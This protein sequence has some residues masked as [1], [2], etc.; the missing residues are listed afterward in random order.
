[1]WLNSKKRWTNGL[2]ALRCFPSYWVFFE[3]IILRFFGTSPFPFLRHS[4]RGFIKAA[5]AI[6]YEK[7][8]YLFNKSFFP[9]LWTTRNARHR[10]LGPSFR[11]NNW[12]AIWKFVII[13]IEIFII[14]RNKFHE[15]TYFYLSKTK[16]FDVSK[17]K[18]SSFFQIDLT[19]PSQIFEA[20]LLETA[21]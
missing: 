15:S 6:S 11:K 2:R 17:V 18:E 4:Q 9:D 12:S 8:I 10:T 21:T 14:W 3:K 13:S 1:M 16:F 20:H 5:P 19:D 7:L